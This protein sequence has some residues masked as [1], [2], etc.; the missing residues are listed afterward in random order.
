MRWTNPAI[1]YAVSAGGAVVRRFAVNPGNPSYRPVTMH[2]S[3]NRIAVLFVDL[4]K[5]RDIVKVVDLEGRD[6]AA[7][8]ESAQGKSANSQLGAAFTC[9]TTN[10]ER[11]TFLSV[12]EE[13][14]LEIKIAQ[15]R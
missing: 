8:E 12:G 10:P 4:A 13:N 14:A 15:P 11:F 2:V 5:S 1:L 9:Y 6:L 3:G 7:Y